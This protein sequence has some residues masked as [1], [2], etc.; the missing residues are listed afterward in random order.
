M[1]MKKNDMYFFQFPVAEVS[2]TK[3]KDS[4]KSTLNLKGI[5]S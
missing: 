2:N 3:R 4:K 1:N 5:Q